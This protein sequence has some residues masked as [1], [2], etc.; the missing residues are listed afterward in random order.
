MW[1]YAV[2]IPYSHRVFTFLLHAEHSAKNCETTEGEEAREGV[3]FFL[4]LV[5][6]LPYHLYPENVLWNHTAKAGPM[7]LLIYKYMICLCC[8]WLLSCVQFFAVPW[9]VACQAPLSMG[10]LQARILEWLAMPS[11]RGSSQPRDWTQVSR[12]AGRFFTV[13][14]TREACD[15]FRYL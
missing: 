8:A 14:V 3:W 7:N 2:H 15:L 11:S 13:W 12:I 6:V 1:N 10:I 9:P 4:P 5:K